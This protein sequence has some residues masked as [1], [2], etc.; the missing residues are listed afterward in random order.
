MRHNDWPWP[1]SYIPR[2][3]TTFPGVPPTLLLGNADPDG[4]LD[5]T[6][7]GTWALTNPLYLTFQTKNFWYFGFGVRYDYNSKDY[8]FPRFTIKHYK[9]G[10]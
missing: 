7:P 3:W 1:F 8:H 2:E 9:G 5:I 10:L 4:H 6:P